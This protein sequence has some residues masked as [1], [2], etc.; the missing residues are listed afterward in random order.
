[1]AEE[2]RRRGG[3]EQRNLEDAYFTC[4]FIHL[5]LHLQVTDQ[6]WPAVGRK[7]ERPKKGDWPGHLEEVGARA[8]AL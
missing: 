1:M 6:Y 2:V 7:Q 4:A 3:E 8:G 5:H